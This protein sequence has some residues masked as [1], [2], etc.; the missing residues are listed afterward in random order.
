M[1]IMTT[2]MPRVKT[3]ALAM[4]TTM[5]PG[6]SRTITTTTSVTPCIVPSS[7]I[8][9]VEQ[10]MSMVLIILIMLIKD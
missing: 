5:K 6:M 10:Q 2:I 8:F 4:T 3:H 9:H 7:S 1:A